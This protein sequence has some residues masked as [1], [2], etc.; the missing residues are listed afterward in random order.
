[1][2]GTVGAGV[3]GSDVVVST[4][5]GV[6]VAVVGAVVVVVGTG[7]VVGVAV[8]VSAAVEFV[9]AGVVVACATVVFTALVVFA[10]V[11]VRVVLGGSVTRVVGASTVRGK[12]SVILAAVSHGLLYRK[13]AFVDPGLRPVNVI[14]Y[15]Y[16]RPVRS[17]NELSAIPYAVAT[18]AKDGLS[19]VTIQSYAV[20]GFPP[21]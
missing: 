3:V 9:G 11:G 2:C 18:V 17:E 20:A 12:I 13:V 16:G 19:N 10:A 14:L 4:G 6:G 5:V 8:V 1:M 7:V 21:L 15:T